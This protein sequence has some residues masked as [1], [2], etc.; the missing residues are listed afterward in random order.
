MEVVA[1]AAVSVDKPLKSS[2]AC[3]VEFGPARKGRR[4]W[5]LGSPRF[6]LVRRYWRAPPKG[7]NHGLPRAEA[8]PRLGRL[9]LLPPNHVNP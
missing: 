5:H 2:E 3:D 4:G 1:G 6:Q 9:S 8:I 7:R